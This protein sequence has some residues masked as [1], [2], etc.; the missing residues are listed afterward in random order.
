MELKTSA[1]AAAQTAGDRQSQ[2]R[3]LEATYSQL[4]L[5]SDDGGEPNSNIVR[6]L[7]NTGERTYPK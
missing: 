5:G 2:E 3:Y 4:E 7:S 1:A 6:E